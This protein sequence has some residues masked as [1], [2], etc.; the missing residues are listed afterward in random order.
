MNRY[1]AQREVFNFVIH[2]GSFFFFLTSVEEEV[3]LLQLL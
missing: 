2:S 1:I 3:W